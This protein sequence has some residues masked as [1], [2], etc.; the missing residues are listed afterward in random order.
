ML[1]LEGP[2]CA[3]K[4]TLLKELI[5]RT[6]KRLSS[7]GSLASIVVQ[8]FGLL[9][10]S[11][12]YYKDYLDRISVDRVS[13]RFHFSELIYGPVLRGQVNPKFDQIRRE[14]VLMELL[15]TGSYVVYCRPD[16]PVLVRRYLAKKEG[17]EVLEGNA[18][19]LEDKHALGCKC[20]ERLTS[21]FDELDWGIP[22]QTINTEGD[23]NEQ[24]ETVLDEW[25][26]LCERAF[27]HQTLGYQGWGSLQPKVLV[28]GERP[29]YRPGFEKKYHLRPFAGP[30]PQQKKPGVIS[31]SSDWVF[32]MMREAGLKPRDWHVTNAFRR[33]CTKTIIDSEVEFLR[34]KFI[35]VMGNV[36]KQIVVDELSLDTAF[37]VLF[38]S[39]PQYL[40]RFFNKTM[41]RH[42]DVLRGFLK[43]KAPGL[44]TFRPRSER[45][46]YNISFT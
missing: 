22:F 20:L 28:V 46:T 26:L 17:D 38:M 14:M 4:T 23:L 15:T 30:G 18:K 5:A 37:P 32:T 40:R 35:V 39:H 31:N 27:K 34:P 12:D 24:V 41:P 7:D 11:W 25:F 6:I 10:D 29:N 2:D 16:S 9:P 33:D 43:T 1:I 36:A 42:I 44:V 8:H 45:G 21:G 3:G 13:D 19:K